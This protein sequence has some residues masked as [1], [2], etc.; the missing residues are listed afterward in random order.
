MKPIKGFTFFNTLIKNKKVKIGSLVGFGVAS[1]AVL[2]MNQN[3]SSKSRFSNDTSLTQATAFSEEDD[4]WFRLESAKI[5]IKQLNA[6]DGFSDNVSNEVLE[7]KSPTTL[8]K[9]LQTSVNDIEKMLLDQKRASNDTAVIKKYTS[10]VDLLSNARDMLLAFYMNQG[11]ALSAKNLEEAKAQLKN[12]I[13]LLSASLDNLKLSHDQLQAEVTRQGGQISQLERDFM[14]KMSELEEKLSDRIDDVQAD[15]MQTISELNSAL[16]Q[17][18][19][20]NDAEISALDGR[21]INIDA[22]VKEIENKLKPQVE[23]LINL[24]EQTRR[25]LDAFAAQFEELR[26]SGSTSYNEMV[27]GWN[28]SDDLINKNGAQNLNL[29]ASIGEACVLSKE[30]TLYQICVERYPTF[31]GPCE[32]KT[33][34]QC[35]HWNNP[36]IGLT[37][38]QKLEILINLRQEITIEF[39]TQQTTIHKRA[40]FGSASCKTQ[41][42]N[43][44]NG[45]LPASCTVSDLN[46]CGV[47]GQL[48]AL[49]IADINLANN[50]LSISSDMNDRMD[51]LNNDLAAARDYSNQRFAHMQSYV[52]ENF[53]QIRTT[54]EQ[55]FNAIV[56]ALSGV[57]VVSK[58]LYDQMTQQCLVSGQ[59][60]AHAVASKSLITA[61]LNQIPGWNVLSAPAIYTALEADIE[62]ALRVASQSSINSSG[63]GSLASIM[64]SLRQEMF[65]ALDM[66]QN[67]IP[68]YDGLLETRVGSACAAS[69]KK[70][71]PFTNVVGRDPM[72]IIAIG[73]ARRV[74]MADGSGTVGGVK[75]VFDKY[76]SPIIKGSLLQQAFFSAVL[77]YRED[78]SKDVPAACLAA[79]D[80]YAKEVL[81]TATLVRAG[82]AGT[83]VQLL[84]S[85]TFQ[86]ILLNLSEQAKLLADKLESL[87]GSIIARA[88]V[89]ANDSGLKTAVND[90]ALRLIQ[91]STLLTIAAIKADE[92]DALTASYRELVPSSGQSQFD[93][94]LQEYTRQKN[95]LAAANA[96][97]FAKLNAQ[98]AELKAQQAN[99]NTINANVQKQIKDL[100]DAVGSLPTMAAV[101][102]MI[103]ALNIP[104][105]KKQIQILNDKV[106]QIVI[107]DDFTPRITA[108][109]HNFDTGAADCNTNKLAALAFPTS[110]QF[111]GGYLLCGVNFRRTTALGT[112]ASP[113]FWLKMWG[114]ATKIDV[115]ALS[116]STQVG[117]MQGVFTGM[118]AG[119]SKVSGSGVNLRLAAG[120]IKDGAFMMN[121][122]ALLNYFTNYQVSRTN[123]TFKIT[124][125]N[126]P[127]NKTGATVNYTFTLYSPLVLA[128]NQAEHLTTLHVGEG[129]NFDLKGQG[130]T[131]Q[132]G[133][134][135]PDRGAFLAID[136]NN[137][138]KIDDGRELFGQASKLANG[139]DAVNGFEALA[140]YD[141]NK[142]GVIDAKDPVFKKLKLWFDLKTDG[143]TQRGELVSLNRMNVKKISLEY[144]EVAQ[145]KQMD[146]EN[147]VLYRAKFFG[148][149][150]CGD[151]G[152]TV[153]DVFFNNVQTTQS[154]LLAV[155]E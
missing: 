72:D 90:V 21:V 80:G 108:V 122:P 141:K 76:K 132:T 92:C 70:K 63:A 62:D 87:E 57:Q 48:I 40:L 81:S 126:E 91:S 11:F 153:F 53:K 73:V 128:F 133:W 82:E 138:G 113:K 13:V 98:I 61:S 124:P 85:A 155:K 143:R 10:L 120:E 8:A 60:S 131:Q 97:T 49:R 105:I 135:A 101:K 64:L 83:I 12:S 14:R 7:G 148:P 55:K 16:S 129:V 27:Q 100:Q 109:R 111:N 115:K 114:S 127:H 39:L 41:C 150:S 20:Q 116:G 9:L 79:V 68:A 52:D 102:E 136:L 77:D 32:G 121:Y 5:K 123:P 54:T 99:Q 26:N 28:C 67:N 69:F 24:A 95:A 4:I 145:D 152:C 38:M 78:V 125:Y 96:D 29:P 142:D 74:L 25:D 23:Y 107:V 43:L 47:E 103:D 149:K 117:T 50:M 88:V 134:V 139:Q 84:N 45:N 66:D 31:C 37:P 89:P 22:R 154:P 6:I 51:A 104:E 110:S 93:L 65:D 3:C 19:A 56:S 94:A 130:A 112:N 46:E 119:D 17:R 86:G 118:K 30:Q 34:A 33:M 144:K 58:P 18:I 35:A 151:A 137:N 36:S 106:N 71:T 146:N 1:F 44:S 75:T 2:V 42:L 15:I 59:A 140:A 147:R